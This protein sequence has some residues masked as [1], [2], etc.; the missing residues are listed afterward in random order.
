MP[1]TVQDHRLT[2]RVRQVTRIIRY[3]GMLRCE[4][5]AVALAL[6]GMTRRETLEGLSS[7]LAIARQI[8]DEDLAPQFRCVVEVA[9]FEAPELAAAGRAS[10][11]RHGAQRDQPG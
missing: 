7:W 6:V 5:A 10:S 4:V 1:R 11:F 2:R 9:G 3:R 8:P